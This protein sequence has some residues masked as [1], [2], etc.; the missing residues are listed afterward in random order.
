[1]NENENNTSKPTGCGKSSAK[2]M[3]IGIN[4]DVKKVKIAENQPP[5]FT[6]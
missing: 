2:G 3:V 1:M 4:A 5:N 6:I